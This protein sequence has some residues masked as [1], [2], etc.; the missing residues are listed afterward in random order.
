MES[1]LGGFAFALLLTSLYTLRFRG[2]RHPGRVAA[3][4]AFFLVVE[5]VA[6]RFFLPPG[7]FGPGFAW[8]CLFLTV[9]VLVAAW[10]VRRHERAHGEAE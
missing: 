3:Y 6:T 4:F 2:W 7:A 10:L 5:G 1:I 8:L 9:P